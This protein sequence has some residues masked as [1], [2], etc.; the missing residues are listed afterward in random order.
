[1]INFPENTSTQDNA[2][3][4]RPI[5]EDSP[6]TKTKIA[7]V[8]RKSIQIPEISRQASVASLPFPDSKTMKAIVCNQYG[9]PET[10]IMMDVAIPVPKENEIL[11]KVFAASVN[12]NEWHNL[13]GKPFLVR[14][15]GTGLLKPKHKIPGADIAGKVEAVGNKVTHFK[16][17]DEVFGE[18]GYGGYADYVCVDENRL[19]MKPANLKFEEA[20]A[21]PMAALTALQGLRDKGHI[22]QGQKVLINGASGGVGTF[23]VQLAK[24][25]G[26]E[27]TGVCTTTKMHMV[28]SIGA[29]RVVD[30]TRK[31]ITKNGQSFDLIFDIAAYRS[32][33]DYKK[34]L[35]TGGKYIMAGGA[36][37]MIFQLIMLAAMRF[38]FGSKS[39][40]K[41]GFMIAKISRADLLLLKELL[42]TYKIKPVIDRSFPLHEAA[43][44]LRYFEDG[45]TC[46]KIIIT[47][48]QTGNT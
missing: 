44:A 39:G 15:V 36:V 6:R 11:V 42:E 24:T 47:I 22:R 35:N 40:R 43:S 28:H 45:H 27:V 26:A 21:V 16:P 18:C 38:F 7:G 20:A 9:S 32:V 13:T 33:S 31:D 25:Y 41:M 8:L 1:M 30:Y 10:M 17:G 19:V 37:K 5:V 4:E 3:I 34:I 46:G 12:A 29:D 48:D 14:L 2:L 23:A